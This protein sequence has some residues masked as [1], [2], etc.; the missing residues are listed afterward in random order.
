MPNNIIFIP[1]EEF[2][3]FYDRLETK[4]RQHLQAVITNI[5]K[6][7]LQTAIR[8]KWVKKIERNL[9][10]IRSRSGSNI[11]RAIYFKVENNNYYITH[12]FT[13]KTQKTPKREIN[14]AKEIRAHFMKGRE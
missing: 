5:T 7:G 13:K 2:E 4:D 14:H 10:E 9:Y 3:I 8:L 12:G 1:S 6:F 11:Q